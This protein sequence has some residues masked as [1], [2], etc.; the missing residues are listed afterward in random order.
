MGLATWGV[1]VLWDVGYRA[2]YDLL[3]MATTFGNYRVEEI[4]P[5]SGERGSDA[6]YGR[7][8]RVCKCFTV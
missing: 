5:V 4:P 8:S 1:F 2:R 7:N 3:G 6:E